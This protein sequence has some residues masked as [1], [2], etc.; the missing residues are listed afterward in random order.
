MLSARRSAVLVLSLAVLFMVGLAPTLVIAQDG[1]FGEPPEGEVPPEVEQDVPPPSKNIDGFEEL[2]PVS[3][4]TLEELAAQAEESQTAQLTFSGDLRTESSSASSVFTISSVFQKYARLRFC[5][6]T[7]CPGGI[8]HMAAGTGLRNTGYGTIRLR[9]V[10][11]TATAASAFLY[12]GLIDSTAPPPNPL[13]VNFNGTNINTFLVNTAPSPC[14]GAG[15]FRL[16]RAPVLTL[17][18]AGINADY[19]VSGVP[20]SVTNGQ[21]PWAG[22]AANPRA[23]G[24]SLVVL[25]TDRSVPRGTRTQ[26]HHPIVTSV[27][28]T[29][30]YN[31][32]LTFAINS[33][34]VKHTR[35]GADGQ[36]GL[37]CPRAVTAISNERTFIGGPVGFALNQLRGTPGTPPNLDSDWNGTDGEPL[38]QLWDTH[39]SAVPSGFIPAGVANYRV[40]YQSPNDCI[41]PGV[42][43]LTY[44]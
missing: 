15:T 25:Y 32:F 6:T 43:V 13:V 21:C 36:T 11:P 42:H 5:T 22:A 41:I 9:G 24:A 10:P 1:D 19:R 44:R 16:Y 17:L 3:E 12:V 18:A 14:W 23:E 2:N 34:P 40:Q 8:D 4:E 33:G 26:I 31:H 7:G 35:L 20:S 30:T 38:N 28:G 29:T 27:F 39:T 37:G